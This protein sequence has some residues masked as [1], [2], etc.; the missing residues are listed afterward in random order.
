MRNEGFYSVLTEAIE[1]AMQTDDLRS[2]VKGKR[3]YLMYKNLDKGDKNII[4]NV[5]IDLCGY[6]FK[7]LIEE[8]ESKRTF[9]GKKVLD[10][11]HRRLKEDERRSDLYYYDIRHSDNDISEPATIE[12]EVLVNRIATIGLESQLRSEE[13]R[14]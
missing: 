1:D 14:V 2:G 10:I 7:T 3:L 11:S 6:S 4:N 12:K 8:S 5:F 9:M 13:S